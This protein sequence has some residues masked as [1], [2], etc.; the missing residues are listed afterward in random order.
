MELLQWRVQCPAHGRRSC[1]ASQWPQ[2]LWS[3]RNSSLT[4]IHLMRHTQAYDMHRTN[5]KLWGRLYSL[6]KLINCS[7]QI[8]NIIHNSLGSDNIPTTSSLSSSSSLF[9]F[10]SFFFFFLHNTE[11]ASQLLI[12]TYTAKLFKHFRAITVEVRTFIEPI[13]FHERNTE[14]KPYFLSFNPFR[15]SLVDFTCEYSVMITQG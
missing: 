10:L 5:I 9:L 12:L 14:R 1:C 3:P 2:S 8:L 13:H 6:Y 11:V 4:T 15:T 7:G